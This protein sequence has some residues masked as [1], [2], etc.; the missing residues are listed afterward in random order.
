MK[1]TRLQYV[2]FRGHCG[3]KHASPCSV[4]PLGRWDGLLDLATGPAAVPRRPDG[5][6]LLDLEL[7]QALDV[8]LAQI[9]GLPALAGG[10]ACDTQATSRRPWLF[11]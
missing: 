3:A 9:G 2:L 4:I 6:A 7:H 11:E 1:Q 10:C 8:R 5:L